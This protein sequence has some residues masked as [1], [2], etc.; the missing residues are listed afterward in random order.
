M[1]ENDKGKISTYLKEGMGLGKRMNL[2]EKRICI[3][4]EKE[5]SEE[6]NGSLEKESSEDNREMEC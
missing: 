6:E 2:R 1:K 4:K 5:A 3:R